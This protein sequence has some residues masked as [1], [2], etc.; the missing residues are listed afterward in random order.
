MTGRDGGETAVAIP[1]SGAKKRPLR[2][3][4]ELC[5]LVI[6]LYPMMSAAAQPDRPTGC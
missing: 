1:S 2:L 6:A 3:L 5:A 4:P